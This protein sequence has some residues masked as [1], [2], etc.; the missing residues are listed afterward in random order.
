MGSSFTDIYLFWFVI[1][2][3]LCSFHRILQIWREQHLLRTGKQGICLKHSLS[4]LGFQQPYLLRTFHSLILI[5]LS[6]GFDSTRTTQE[7]PT[8]GAQLGT[9][10]EPFPLSDL[11]DNQPIVVGYYPTSLFVAIVGDGVCSETSLAKFKGSSK[12]VERCR[13][14]VEKIPREQ[15]IS[16]DLPG[17]G[18]TEFKLRVYIAGSDDAKMVEAYAHLNPDQVPAPFIV[19]ISCLPVAG[20]YNPSVVDPYSSHNTAEK[21]RKQAKLRA[22]RFVRETILDQV[23]AGLSLHML[24]GYEGAYAA[25][26]VIQNALLVHA[27][28]IPHPTMRSALVFIAAELHG[29]GQSAA[30]GWPL[31]E[32]SMDLDSGLAARSRVPRDGSSDSENG[33]EGRG[34]FGRAVTKSLVCSE[35]TRSLFGELEDVCIGVDLLLSALPEYQNCDDELSSLLP[36][37]SSNQRG[38]SL[39][40]LTWFQN[41]CED[42]ARHPLG[43]LLSES[44]VSVPTIQ[45]IEPDAQARK[46][47][48]RLLLSKIESKLQANE[49][50][51]HTQALQDL[52]QVFEDARASFPSNGEANNIFN[53][54]AALMD[55]RI[56]SIDDDGSCAKPNTFKC[57]RLQDW[58]AFDGAGGFVTPWTT[59]GDK[60]QLGVFGVVSRSEGEGDV[61]VRISDFAEWRADFARDEISVPTFW[62][63]VG[64]DAWLRLD[65]PR[66]QYRDFLA[67][68]CGWLRAVR[69]VSSAL[70]GTAADAD[71]EDV[72]AAAAAA[73]PNL[74]RAERSSLLATS[75]SIS[76]SRTRRVAAM[77]VEQAELA[78][79]ELR[80]V[81]AG[82]PATEAFCETLL[83]RFHQAQRREVAREAA[84]RAWLKR[85]E[86]PSGDGQ[87]DEDES[88]DEDGEIADEEVEAVEAG[89]GLPGRG[90]RPDSN[91][92][93]P[94]GEVASL[95][96]LDRSGAVCD[97]VTDPEELII[98]Q[99][100]Y[101]LVRV[102]EEASTRSRGRG[103]PR[104]GSQEGTDCA[105][106]KP[107]A[108]RGGQ[109]GQKRRKAAA[110]KDANKDGGEDADRGTGKEAARDQETERA[111]KRQKAAQRGGD[112]AGGTKRVLKVVAPFEIPGERLFSGLPADC[113]A[114]AVEAWSCVGYVVGEVMGEDLDLDWTVL[115]GVLTDPAAA[116]S[117]VRSH[118]F[119][120]ITDVLCRDLPGTPEDPGHVFHGRP[121]NRFTWPELLRQ[122]LALRCWEVREADGTAAAAAGAGDE[123]AGSAAA[124]A[125]GGGARGMYGRAEELRDLAALGETLA[126]ERGFEELSLAARL[127]MLSRLCWLS[128]DSQAVRRHMDG[129]IE[130]QQ[131][132]IA[133][134]REEMWARL[135][136]R[137]H[138]G[139]G[140]GDEDGDGDDAAEGRG[141][142]DEE[143]AGGRDT[144]GTGRGCGVRRE[145]LG[146]DRHGRRY[147]LL[148]GTGFPATIVVEPPSEDGPPGRPDGPSTRSDVATPRDW[149]AVRREA[150][151]RALLGLLQPRGPREAALKERLERAARTVIA[152][153][154]A[155]AAGLGTLSPP[156][157]EELEERPVDW[158][159]CA[160]CGRVCRAPP[161]AGHGRAFVGCFKCDLVRPGG[162]ASAEADLAWDAAEG[163]CVEL[164]NPA[165]GWERRRRAVAGVILVSYW[166]YSPQAPTANEDAAIGA[167]SRGEKVA[168][169]ACSR[170]VAALRSSED[171]AVYLDWVRRQQPAA[172]S[173]ALLDA[174]SFDFTRSGPCYPPP[175]SRPG[176]SSSI[177][178]AAALPGA[179]ADGR[180]RRDLR[181]VSRAALAHRAR[182]VQ[183]PGAAFLLSLRAQPSA[184]DGARDGEAEVPP[185]AGG[186]VEVRSADGAW[187]AGT[188][189]G[190]DACAGRWNVALTLADD[191]DA[192]GGGDDRRA[193][194]AVHLPGPDARLALPPADGGWCWRGRE[195]VTR[196]KA[197]LLDMESALPDEAKEG[198][199]AARAAAWRDRVRLAGGPGELNARLHELGRAV[200]RAWFQPWWTPWER[201]AGQASQ[202]AAAPPPAQRCRV[203]DGRSWRCKEPAVPGKTVCRRHLRKPP[204]TG[205]LGGGAGRGGGGGGS[206]MAAGL[207]VAAAALRGRGGSRGKGRGVRS[208][209][210][211]GEVAK[212][213][214]VEVLWEGDW[215]QVR[216]SP[217]RIP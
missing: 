172:V 20:L 140:F 22:V 77:L 130:E 78:V 152:G 106:V 93:G 58:A 198:W 168:G 14:M 144:A 94:N 107:A 153:A 192:V 61:V 135:H 188:I 64:A 18:N 148:S 5:F 108:S 134:R 23:S 43:W 75:P 181:V 127:G 171:V 42:L 70:K 109:T 212:G 98:R 176:S 202:Q 59:A 37:T 194:A 9:V 32:D 28:S 150:D 48:R 159:R 120:A 156:S 111:P 147:W 60:G 182:G 124:V 170:I 137:E 117:D 3:D 45:R 189:V 40:G 49:Y 142:S 185:Y 211:G 96:R 184:A 128:L 46:G 186:R 165:P 161:R 122:V 44:D 197:E 83:Q 121:M 92:K 207:G 88:C 69:W 174:A 158:A 33:E 175:A 123:E 119:M 136:E 143:A 179:A 30:Q 139:M 31:M 6:M 95:Y 155:S 29:R 146:L 73:A 166:A 118:L 187:R 51:D 177:P 180:R 110:G 62:V 196:I 85:R 132:A 25:Q 90:R 16:V 91:S 205:G 15:C 4:F 82:L 154:A 125:A 183:S 190:Y 199:G 97:G 114:A 105:G 215:W 55:K 167:A 160:E 213:A 208:L 21:L 10:T 87:D 38:D 193:R 169:G 104:P 7:V 214:F 86:R 217:T 113:R 72:C 34:L 19:L 162:C 89:E 13:G 101:G 52:H 126:A 8:V 81:A 76:L 145:A 50:L 103:G 102:T 133:R 63:R 173:G 26:D 54:L 195:A 35:S 36:L 141:S 53:E 1:H 112:A 116:R 68:Q 27:I 79:T 100:V 84:R 65:R 11:G 163:V 138:D 67:S 204:L 47:K 200:R 203:H 149:V 157:P 66:A 164:D 56:R 24:R 74:E 206:V 57:F 12:I 17:E 80:R 209:R 71:F 210:G 201:F 115:E 178:A 131:R 151:V 39:T 41:L 129:C 216:A 99:I 2:E 191:D